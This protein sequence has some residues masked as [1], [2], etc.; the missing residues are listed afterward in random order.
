MSVQCP[1]DRDSGYSKHRSIH[2]LWA[3][4][5]SSSILNHVCERRLQRLR[6]Q[7]NNCQARRFCPCLDYQSS[8]TVRS[9]KSEGSQSFADRIMFS[10]RNSWNG[11]VPFEIIKA[12]EAA[13]KDDRVRAIVFTADSSA[14]AYCSGVSYHTERILL[15]TNSGLRPTYLKV[16]SFSRKMKRI[17]VRGPVTDTIHNILTD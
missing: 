11:I 17:P 8:K 1:A 6:V 12:F 14:P 2:I 15:L 4:L 5:N 7:R 16:G 10:R 3:T 9:F 13:D